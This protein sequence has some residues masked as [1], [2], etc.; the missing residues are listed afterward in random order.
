MRKQLAFNDVFSERL[1]LAS[2][3]A[4]P[5]NR[6]RTSPM[7]LVNRSAEPDQGAVADDFG[8]AG[9]FAVRGSWYGAHGHRLF[10]L[11]GNP[12]GAEDGAGPDL[13]VRPAA[14]VWPA[15]V[16]AIDL[17]RY[18]ARKS[19][20]T[21]E[22]AAQWQKRYRI[23]AMIQAAVIGLWC[24]ASLLSNDDAVV[25]MISL[26]VTTGIVAGAAGRAYGRQSIFR[27]QAVIMFGH[28]CSRV[29][30]A[31]HALL[32]RDVDRE[33]RVSC[34]DHPALGQSAP[35]IPARRSWRGNAKRRSRAS[36]IPP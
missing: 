36:S 12:D 35:N 17:R 3:K 9:R 21:A 8:G 28:A 6:T 10:G 26:S 20:L 19:T 32:H 31:R 15:L 14:A 5:P 13:G 24:S 1:H 30:V 25:H 34:C 11:L 33:R 18:H 27:L 22:E 23:G 16:R 7:Q 4:T 2:V 29:G